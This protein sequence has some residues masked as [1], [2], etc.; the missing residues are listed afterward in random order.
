M[1]GVVEGKLYDTENST[2][3]H[4]VGFYRSGTGRDDYTNV[5]GEYT[6]SLYETPN[7]GFFY[8][9]TF[10]HSPPDLHSFEGRTDVY[11]SWARDR[12]MDDVEGAALVWLEH[13]DGAEVILERW[14][15]RIVA[16]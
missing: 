7:G 13:H 6:Q 10:P 2:L 8:V 11:R 1:K 12:G 15:D 4:R 9:Y 14:P 16:G 3:V 5:P